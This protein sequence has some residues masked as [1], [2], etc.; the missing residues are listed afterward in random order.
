MNIPKN[1]KEW[2][3]QVYLD[4]YDSTEEQAKDHI[5]AVFQEGKDNDVIDLKLTQESVYYDE[6]Y[7]WFLKGYVPMT[8]K[9]IEKAAA[10]RKA[11]LALEKENKRKMEEAD[12]SALKRLAKKYKIK[13]PEEF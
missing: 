2:K 5:T 8:E 12:K 4:F 11:A 10:K 3:R 13:L 9:E 7:S 6:G 1:H